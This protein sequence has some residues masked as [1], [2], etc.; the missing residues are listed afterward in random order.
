MDMGHKNYGGC[1]CW[2]RAI[3]TDAAAFGLRYGAHSLDCPIYRESWDI[4]D[5]WADERQRAEGEA[6]ASRWTPAP[7]GAR[8]VAAIAGPGTVGLVWAVR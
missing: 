8:V 3:L 1:R 2:V 5:R 6:E 7:D 4:L